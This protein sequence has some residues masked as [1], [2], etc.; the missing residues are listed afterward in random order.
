MKRTNKY[1]TQFTLTL[2]FVAVLLASNTEARSEPAGLPGGFKLGS[3]FEEAQRHAS[4]R[5]WELVRLSPALPGQ[6]EVEGNTGAEVGLFV[7]D[8]TVTSVRQYEPGDLDEFARIVAALQRAR[9]QWEPDIQVVTF[10]AGATQISNVDVKFAELGGHK[11]IVTLSSTA[12]RL[13]I[14]TNYVMGGGC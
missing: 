6:W 2:S 13:G 11:V 8:D 12:G 4:S 3:S 7:C 14:S 1:L 10:A 5:G 9:N